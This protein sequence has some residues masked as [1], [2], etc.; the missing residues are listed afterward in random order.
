MR[1]IAFTLAN[2]YSDDEAIIKSREI[3]LWA[4]HVHQLAD[5]EG[6][7]I[8][9]GTPSAKSPF[10]PYDVI[11]AEQPNIGI[12]TPCRSYCLCASSIAL[13]HA[14][15][16]YQFDLLLHVSS[17]AV[18]GHDLRP[19]AEEFMRRPELIMASNWGSGLEDSVYLMK[20]AG[21]P[22]FLNNRK[23]ANIIPEVDDY[24]KVLLPEQEMA[25]IFAGKWWNPWPTATTW[26][27]DDPHW[28]QVSDDEAMKW[29]LILRPST[30]L[31]E[32]YLK[33]RFP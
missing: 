11:Q 9:S 32:R 33:A 3:A 12:Y 28:K 21:I 17:D 29:P 26:R 4:R 1:I 5:V 30:E 14:L 6:F 24:T 15:T 22:Q 16:N 31:R 13:S 19:M 27:R 20:R 25:Q 7:F 2:W 23:R 18:C 8:A 10:I